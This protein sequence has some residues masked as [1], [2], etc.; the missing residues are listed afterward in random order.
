MV[1]DTHYTLFT[2]WLFTNDK[3]AVLL[4]VIMKQNGILHLKMEDPY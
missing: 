4:H 3:F 1:S 2:V